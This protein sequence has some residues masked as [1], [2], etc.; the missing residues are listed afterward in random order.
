MTINTGKITLRPLP[1]LGSSL[2]RARPAAS[3]RPRP[4]RQAGTCD[5]HART[6]AEERLPSP[7]TGRV[8]RRTVHVAAIG[9][10]RRADARRAAQVVRQSSNAQWVGFLGV[11]IVILFLAI[12]WFTSW[13]AGD[14]SRG[15]TP[16]PRPSRSPPW[17]AA[18]TCTGELRALSAPTAGWHRSDAQPAGQAVRYLSVDYINNV[19]VVGGRYVCGNRIR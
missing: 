10:E 18:T 2:I 19:L 4:I 13:H 8:A 14:P 9:P 1:A 6:G 3:D 11:V 15:S 16:R 5:R 12:Y 7:A 17:N